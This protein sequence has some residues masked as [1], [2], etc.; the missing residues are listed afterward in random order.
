MRSRSVSLAALVLAA[1]AAFACEG[2]SAS[3]PP[4]PA[5]SG[6]APAGWELV[7]ER[8]VAGNLDLFVVPAGGGTERRLTDDPAEDGLP[9]WS[10]DG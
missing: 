1:A 2:R 7:L 5:A 3:S 8:E 6:G 4:A 10:P 9:R